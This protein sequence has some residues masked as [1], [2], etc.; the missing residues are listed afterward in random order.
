M[1]AVGQL[2]PEQLDSAQF[3]HDQSDFLRVL[4]NLGLDVELYASAF[5]PYPFV[6]TQ[7]QVHE[8]RLL[9][10]SLQRAI[11]AVV[12]NFTKDQRIRDVIQ[13]NNNEL[14]L[15][16]KVQNRPYA[17]GGLR[18]DFLFAKDGTAMITEIN[19]RFP[20][21]GFLS[22]VLL[23]RAVDEL[24]LPVAS[25]AP[26][27]DLE[28][29]LMARIG[30]PA[31]MTLLKASEPGWD[32]NLLQSYIG[33][34]NKLRSP[35]DISANE[36]ADTGC[37]VLELHQ[38]ELVNDLNADIQNQILSHKNLL[39]DLRTILIAH[40]KRLLVL[41]STSDVLRDYLAQEDVTRIRKHVIP[42]WVKG[43]SPDKIGEAAATHK[44][45][46]AKPPRSGKG[47]GIV[48]SDQLSPMAWKQTLGSIGDDWILQPYIEQQ[49][50]AIATLEN[51]KVSIRPMNVVGLLPTLDEDCF[52]P[53]M[54]RA[55]ADDIV[56]VARGGTILAPALSDSHE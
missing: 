52:G 50:F 13:L 19:G 47:A 12:D 33:R 17:S 49:A 37:L 48:I 56:N 27:K 43:Q 28:D 9:Q 18:P 34:K 20:I 1:K 16:D 24:S 5:N 32:T 39:N 2:R 30:D 45:W 46:L 22:S 36:I 25:I 26:L 8:W 4:G 41:L 54:F 7:A 55:A 29:K 42:T 35:K 31:R 6:V 53:G 21:N 10:A 14:S 40:D 23:S 38:D 11:V 15:I 51:D 3:Q 44:G